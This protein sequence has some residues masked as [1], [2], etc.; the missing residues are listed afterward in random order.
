MKE[1][2]PHAWMDKKET[3]QKRTVNLYIGEVREKR[4][5]PP[6]EPPPPNPPK[7]GV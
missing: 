2:V 5:N 7:A 1:S 4:V 3:R 6:V